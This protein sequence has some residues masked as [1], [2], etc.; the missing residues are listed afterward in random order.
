MRTMFISALLAA[1]LATPA[2]A[3]FHLISMD[4]QDYVGKYPLADG[5]L[6]T[7]TQHS[8]KL[9]AQV[10]GQATISL[11]QTA[12]ATFAAPDRTLVL[13]FDQRSSGD[14]AGVTLRTSADTYR[15]V[16]R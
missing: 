14:V 13:T 3:Q 10:D 12:P 8:R 16:S 9:V 11:R 1:T 7:I 5:R 6:L 15:Q 2:Q 4:L